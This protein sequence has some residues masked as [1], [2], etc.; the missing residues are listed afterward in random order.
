MPRRALVIAF[1]SCEPSRSTHLPGVRRRGFAVALVATLALLA[2]LAGLRELARARSVQ[3]FG[4]IIHRVDTAEPQV[5]LTFDDGPTPLVLDSIVGLLASRGV[6][7]TFFVPGASVAEAPS[8]ARRLVTA[9]HELGNHSYSHQRMVLRSMG[10][11]RAEVERT[12]SLIRAVGH[13]G[14]IHFRPPYGYKLVVLPW[15]LARTGR[16]TVTCDIEP[17]SY[18]A[19]AATRDG[20]VHHVLEYVR[21]GSIILLHIWYPSRATSLAAVGPLIDSLH[22]RGYDVGTVRDLLASAS[23]GS[24]AS[25][26]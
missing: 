17:D 13:Q 15:Y 19:V 10:F 1:P 8:L 24:K 18:P 5:A 12:D 16:A 4:R 3:L 14:A 11:V 21:P 25:F 2:A 20:I 22:A 7:A 9:G 23:R 6:R 26:R